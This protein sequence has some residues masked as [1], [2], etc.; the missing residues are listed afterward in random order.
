MLSTEE[1]EVA[2]AAVVYPRSTPGKPTP[3]QARFDYRDAI[4]ALEA[5]WQPWLAQEYASDLPES[6][7]PILFREAW[8]DGHSNGYR[9]V[10]SKY[11]DRA[12][13]ALLIKEH[14]SA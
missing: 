1:L 8:E 14:L 2:T 13:F 11:Q 9:E 3:V 6:L 12:E 4:A 7:H 10:E 5:D